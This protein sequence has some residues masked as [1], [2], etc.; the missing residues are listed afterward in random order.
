MRALHPRGSFQLDGEKVQNT[1]AKT[2]YSFDAVNTNLRTEVA[3]AL[4]DERKHSSP[5]TALLHIN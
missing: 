1:N 4:L 2:D 5:L 3:G